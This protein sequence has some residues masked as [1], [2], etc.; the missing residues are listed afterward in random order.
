MESKRQTKTSFIANLY[1]TLISMRF[2]IIILIV[3][4]AASLLSMLINEY[5]NF[6]TETSILYKIFQQHSPYSSWWYSLLLWFLIISVFLC[7]VQNTGPILRSIFSDNFKATDLLKNSK[8]AI[9]FK[10]SNKLNTEKI[11]RALKKHFF[12]IVEK[13]ENNETLIIASKFKWGASGHLLTHISL[14]VIV[15]GSII[16][17][18]TDKQDFR[19]IIAQEFSN[20]EYHE[21]YPD[22]FT[23]NFAV[24]DDEQYTMVVDSFRVR[25]YET[26]HGPSISDFQSYVRLFDQAGNLI[27]QH[28]LTVNKPLILKHVSIH[29]SDYKPIVNEF[30][31]NVPNRRQVIAQAQ[32]N[33]ELMQNEA[34]WISGLSLRA[35]KGKNIIFA[36]MFIS[37]VGLVLAFML[38]PRHIW[39]AQKNGTITMVGRSVKNKIAFKNEL[40]NI[41]DRIKNE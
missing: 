27:K 31:I 15:I 22:L 28:E 35:N 29:Q 1:N 26:G 5:P 39:I 12:R 17:S 20:T 13:E 40:D 4:G 24:S 23:W 18:N 7:V 10:S 11:K 6:F 8:D 33:Q 14:L 3:L 32:R 41:I 16:Y 25:Y 19:Y 36:G 34:N 30:F 38:W 9:Q 2:A 21:K 37:A